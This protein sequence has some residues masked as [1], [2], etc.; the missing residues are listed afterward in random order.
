MMK[1][2]MTATRRRHL[3]RWLLTNSRTAGGRAAGGCKASTIPATATADTPE[4][5]RAD[6]D[7]SAFALGLGATA[8]A[9]TLPPHRRQTG[10]GKL[11]GHQPPKNSH[12]NGLKAFQQVSTHSK[13][14]PK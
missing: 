11:N 10:G 3:S 9:D 14:N 13:D 5:L 12:P 2:V 1:A 7:L 8:K 6:P 4:A